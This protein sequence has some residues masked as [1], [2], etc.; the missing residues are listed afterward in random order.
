MDIVIL[1]PHELIRWVLYKNAVPASPISIYLTQTRVV[2]G[3]NTFVFQ[4]H[5]VDAL[6]DKGWLC[7]VGDMFQFDYERADLWHRE[8]DKLLSAARSTL[9]QKYPNKRFS[10]EGYGLLYHPECVDHNVRG[11]VF[12]DETLNKYV[13]TAAG[14]VVHAAA[15][16]IM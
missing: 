3:S 1:D 11:F 4:P 7:T 2:C 14:G 12:S 16:H 13:V 15:I 8:E 5:I 10:D 9:V 6:R